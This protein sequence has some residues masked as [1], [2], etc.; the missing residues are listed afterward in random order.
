[1][2]QNGNFENGWWRKTHTGQEFGE[3]FV[4]QDWT[5][6]WVD[7]VDIYRPEMKVIPKQPPFLD[8]P[9]IQSGQ[10]A[11]Q[12]FKQ[13][14]LISAGIYQQINV[15]QD[16]ILTVTAF[17]HA[18]YSMRDDAHKS[19][20]QDDNGNWHTIHN[21]DDGVNL[22]LGVGAGNPDPWSN[23]IQ[24]FTQHYYDAYE[25]IRAEVGVNAGNV[26]IYLRATN[27][28]PFKHV[29]IYWDNVNASLQPLVAECYGEPREQYNR[30]YWL[31]PQNSTQEDLTEVAVL[32]YP[33]RGTVGF[34]ADDAGIGDLQ[35]KS[36]NIIHNNENDWD[37][38]EIEDFF[39]T[40]YPGTMIEH[41]YR[42]DNN[43]PPTNPPPTNPPD[44]TLRSNNLIGLHSGYAKERWDE[45]LT[46][47][48]PTVQKCFSCGF[49]LEAKS[50]AQDALV[51]WRRYSDHD[52]D[53]DLP[54]Y[55]SANKLVDF[56]EAEIR[57]TANNLG[58]SYE[59]LLQLI[60]GIVIESLNEK[61]PTFAVPEL[62]KAVEFDV[63]FCNIVK[64]RF[65]GYLRP[66]VLTAAI[67]NP[68]ETEVQYLLPAAIAAIENN[69]LLA[70]HAYWTANEHQDYLE[71]K[72]QWHAGRWTEWDKYFVSQGYYPQYYLGEGGIVYS[73]TGNDFHSGKGWKSCGSFE[74]YLTSLDRFN[75][76]CNTWNL[77]NNNRCHGLT[78]FGYGNW[79][80]DDFEIGEG[81]LLLLRDKAVNDWL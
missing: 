15:P 32:A 65:G 48:L 53:L 21:G 64:Q 49:A 7:G 58:I 29:D 76:L 43:P 20:W 3:I 18:W 80:W 41:I 77:Q 5:A 14:G 71:E 4:P 67:G 75:Q 31:L 45:Y 8:P 63:H 11:L 9:R 38:P 51:V 66:G 47:A 33:S 1:M 73:N 61:I 12:Y 6:Y 36:V 28:H 40:Y 26:T 69:G 78:V 81:D 44:V 68:H 17:A 10:Y 70:Y 60:D 39:E 22:M 23:Q 54:L 27:D 30:T 50:L 24:W 55:D 16:G 79:G 2:I 56:Y 42:Y 59:G 13:W 35:N 74:D 62:Q 34:S 52:V 19:E 37:E 25:Q 46:Q 72:W 57:T